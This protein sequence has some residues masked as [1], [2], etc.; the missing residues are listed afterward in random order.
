[1]N[2]TLPLRRVESRLSSLAADIA[3]LRHQ[4]A[5][6]GKK[7]KPSSALSD[8]AREALV[9]Y[10][11]LTPA[12]DED[13]LLQT[14]LKCAMQVVGAGGAGL[15]L[16]DAR[17][18]KLVF[19]AAIGDGAAGIIGQEVP[20][21]GSRHGLAFATGEVQTDTPLY[22]GVE[23]AARARFRNV[24]VAPL[25]I[26]GESVGTISAVNKQGADHF[27]GEDMAAYKLFADLGAVIMRQRCRE[28]VLRRGLA[29]ARHPS[30]A[31]PLALEPEDRQLLELFDAVTRMRHG[32]PEWLPLVKQFID[33]LA[34]SPS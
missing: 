19:R 11:A 25:Q 1:M 15:T 23:N 24:L 18:R 20:L 5:K 28:Q 33:G 10:L 9:A 27:S 17:R 22:A 32:H 8:A 7:N 2:I 6:P 29:G 30:A 14:L 21:K 3:R 4:A 12:L 16:L 34:G 26:A 13:A 31:L